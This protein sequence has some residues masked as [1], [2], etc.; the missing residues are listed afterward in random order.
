LLLLHSWGAHRTPIDAP[1]GVPPLSDSLDEKSKRR[2]TG[3]VMLS[4][5]E[6]KRLQYLARR[7]G[8]LESGRFLIEGVRSAEDLIAS[9][10]VIH[11]AYLAPSIEDTRRGASLAQTLRARARTVSISE[12]ELRSIAG[13]DTPQ[14][15][16]IEADMPRHSLADLDWDGRMT[17]AVA[18]DA[19]QDPGNFGTIV[20]SADAFGLG[21][22]AVLPGTVDPWNPKS[23]RAA[24]GSSLRM[25]I[26]ETS[27]DALLNHVRVSDF[28][29][30]GADVHGTPVREVTPPGRMLLVLG[31]EGAGLCDEVRTACD[32]LVAVP[33]RG[34]AESLNVGVAAGILL[35]E[36]TRE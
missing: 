31:N 28:R 22:V 10:I 7:R 9:G 25:P 17:G 34:A 16:V 8:R 15:V 33:I 29:V 27:L 5:A 23:V 21:F 26:V 35:Y 14:G 13:T 36:L 2:S 11:T 24:A 3:P 12:G 19:V 30:L 18:L 20:R 32:E 1:S 6:T 4:R